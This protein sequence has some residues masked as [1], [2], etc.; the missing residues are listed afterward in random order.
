M[1]GMRCERGQATIEWVGLVLV[2]A[3]VLGALATASPGPNDRSFGAFVSERIF[4]AVGGGGCQEQA[5]GGL[6]LRPRPSVASFGGSFGVFGLRVS[7]VGPCTVH[8]CN[9]IGSHCTV[10][11]EGTRG[12]AYCKARAA[13]EE[14]SGLTKFLRDKFKGCLLG[15]TGAKAFTPFAEELLHKDATKSV[16]NAYRALKKGLSRAKDE[17]RKGKAKPGLIG[18]LGGTIGL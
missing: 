18:C 8:S 11:H 15:A 12:R 2:A 9:P 4:C 6:G 5:E 3:L 1:P 14:P 7:A 17:V 13:A 10:V 16:K